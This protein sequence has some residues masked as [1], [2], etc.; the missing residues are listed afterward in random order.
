MSLV[1]L[2]YSNSVDGKTTSKEKI[3]VVSGIQKNS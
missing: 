1:I 3:S 2:G